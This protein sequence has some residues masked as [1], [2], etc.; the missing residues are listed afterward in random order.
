ML[1][2]ENCYEAGLASIGREPWGSRTVQGRHCD[3][4]TDVVKTQCIPGERVPSF[5]EK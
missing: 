5:R 1:A 4:I 2:A 3:I